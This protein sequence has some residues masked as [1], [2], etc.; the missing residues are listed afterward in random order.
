MKPLSQKQVW[1]KIAPKWNEFRKQIQPEVIEFL[2]NKKGK[3]LDLGCGNGRNMLKKNG[4]AWVGVD[5]S[6]ELLEFARRRVEKEEVEA[7]FVGGDICDLEFDDDSFDY[8]IFVRVLHGVEKRKHKKI[9]KELY[10]VLKRGGSCLIG[11]WSSDQ[12]RMKNKKVGKGHLIP[13]TINGGKVFR[14]VYIYDLKELVRGLENVGFEVT[15]S[16]IKKNNW[17]VVEK[18]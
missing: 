7:E 2:K 8:A 6:E 15:K 16:W 13:W 14:Y 5:F 4:V 11:C 1:N 10:R 18:P 3:I 17:V 12:D 9:L